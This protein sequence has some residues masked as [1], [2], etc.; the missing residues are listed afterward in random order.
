MRAKHSIYLPFSKR[1]WYVNTFISSTQIY[2]WG[3][4][5]AGAM[6]QKH[7]KLPLAK[8]VL[9][10]PNDTEVCFMEVFFFSLS[11]LETRRRRRQ[12]CL[13]EG[14]VQT[15]NRFFVSQCSCSM[16]IHLHFLLCFWTHQ[17]SPCFLSI[18]FCF[19]PEEK[20]WSM[21]A[22]FFFP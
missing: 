12:R 22:F 1:S 4:R 7:S 2:I 5:G 19:L 10:T 9:M 18:Y 8:Q 11:R 15:V 14:G 13:V 21:F 17:T 20:R 3:G 16:Q 6:F